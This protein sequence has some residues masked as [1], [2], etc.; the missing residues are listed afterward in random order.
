MIFF[1]VLL[2]VVIFSH[3][4]VAS[5]NCFIEEYASKDRSN[6][7]K[8]IFVIL[9]VFSHYSQYVELTG[10]WDEPYLAL[11]EHLHQMVVVMFWFYSGYGIMESITNKGLPYVKAMLTRR[12]PRVL[13]NF[14]IAVVLFLIVD[15][16]VHRNYKLSDVILSFVGWSSVGNS[17]WYIFVTLVLYI[18]VFLSFW[19]IKWF[20]EEKGKVIGTI[21]LIILSIAFVYVMMK[22]G[23]PSRYYNTTII[24]PLGVTFSLLKKRL[25]NIILKNDFSYITAVIIVAFI[26]FISYQNRWEYGIEGYT[27]WAISFT[28]LVVLLSMKICFCNNILMWF[29]KHVFSVYIL[30]RIPM[31]LLDKIGVAENHKYIFL[32]L[33]FLCT[34]WGAIVFDNLTDK[35]WKKIDLKWGKERKQSLS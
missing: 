31:I 9:I 28:I 18:L 11:Q 33:V 22:V 27:V 26:Y 19:G 15:F 23:R 13:I 30:Q 14:D 12:F 21:F 7:I 6:A 32:I 29:G 3:V 10:I 16:I 1:L 25:D 20:G 2:L 24:F 35:L 4:H 17:N 5:E 8:G 34:I